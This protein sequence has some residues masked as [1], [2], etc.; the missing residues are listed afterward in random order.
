MAKLHA[1]LL[2]DCDVIGRFE[3]CHVLV[4]RDANYPWCV[5]VPDVENIK[6]IFELSDKEQQLLNQES[7]CLAKNLH[8]L[9]S[10]DKMNV[11]AI[12]N[13]VP[14]LHIH[15]VVR[16]RKDISW[17][18]PVWGAYPAL[19]YSEAALEKIKDDICLLLKNNCPGFTPLNA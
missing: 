13:M 7:V 19:E 11:A 18:K 17:P 16:Y 14:Q 8:D 2:K 5:L 12:G 4:M 1:Q 10:A 3:L 15:H 6:E 9:F